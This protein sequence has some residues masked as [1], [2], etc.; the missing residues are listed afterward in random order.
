[1]RRALATAETV[2]PSILWIDEIEKGFSGLQNGNDSGVSS[3]IFGIFL[4]WMQER[5]TSIC[6]SYF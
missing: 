5:R 2:A 6:Y 4:T 1:M 3:H